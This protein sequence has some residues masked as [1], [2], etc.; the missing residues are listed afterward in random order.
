[1]SDPLIT[2]L[3]NRVQA[4]LAGTGLS[5]R[6]L[7]KLIKT[8]ETHLSSFLAGRTGLSA[9]KSLRLMQVLN[10]TREQ[11]ERKFGRT[12][13]TA[14][15]EHFQREGE[16]M[17]LD[18]SG[19]WVAGIGQDP[20]GGTDITSTPTARDLPNATD[21]QSQTIDFLRDQQKVHRSAIVAIE[22]VLAKLL[23]QRA[24]VSR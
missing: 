11:V 6:R 20:N 7:A 22:E 15:I 16:L 24:K 3:S 12:S 1:M 4:F 14:Q 10:S 8:D 17:R 23:L 19:G 5:Q 13:K 9:E 2:Q 18:N 21:Y